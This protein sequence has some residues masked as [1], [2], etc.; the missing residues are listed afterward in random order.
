MS[1]LQTPHLP[2]RRHSHIARNVVSGQR[3]A[4]LVA[5]WLY[6]FA[7]HYAH[8]VYLNPVW[9]Y[10]GFTI[11]PLGPTELAMIFALVTLGGLAMPE[12]IQR[13][14]SII[15]LL[16]Y[17]IVYIPTIVFSLSIDSNGTARYAPSLFMLS[18]GFCSAC[19]AT[20]LLGK[21]GSV[22]TFHPND[23]FCRLLLAAWLTFGAALIGTYWSIM[24]FSGLDDIYE[25]RAAGTSSN[26]WMGYIQTYFGNILSPALISIGL[27]RRQIYPVAA[28]VVGCLIIY[29]INAQRT[30]F[31][32]PIAIFGLYF[33][34]KANNPIFRSTAFSLI[35]LLPILIIPS[36]FYE[37]DLTSGFVSLFIV[38]RTLSL[39]GLTFSQ[40]FDT[41]D[42]D[43][44]TFWSHI[45]GF[46]LIA[47]APA[48]FSGHSAWPNLG[49][50]IGDRIY[51]NIENNV[52]A[53]LFSGD[54]AAA[55]G[56]F[57]VL[58]I[59]LVLAAWLVLFDKVSRGWDATF[60]ALVALPMGLA[61]T[62]GHFFTTMLSFG[63]LFW[64]LIFHFY[65]PSSGLPKSSRRLRV[66]N[67][68]K[69][70]A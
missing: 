1:S 34:L 67:L 19:L 49:Y 16:L 41:F 70:S 21:R 32:L 35:A 52:N 10:Y 40:Y 59:G 2:P 54:G 24:T 58:V 39:P 13:P 11:R 14:S 20:R 30:I 60:A 33:I 55:A 29:M 5:S 51:G 28:G 22:R 45:K 25:Q 43:G 31:L 27:V 3:Q 48:A 9:D 61:L 69:K 17:I 44:Y 15:L 8:V 56:A 4:L 7:L 53:N 36:T 6:S 38:F 68:R 66:A 26:L 65:K 63:G 46:D 57:G 42:T 64:L 37:S 50:I 12:S 23:L 18:I 47:P 62:N